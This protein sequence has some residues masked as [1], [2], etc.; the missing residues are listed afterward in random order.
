MTDAPSRNGRI[1]GTRNP[2]GVACSHYSYSKTRATTPRA[3]TTRNLLIHNIIICEREFDAD[4]VAAEGFPS[5]L[6][7]MRDFP[8]KL[9]M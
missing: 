7:P 3:I 9:I 1:P 5:R 6:R 4:C 8:G 2:N